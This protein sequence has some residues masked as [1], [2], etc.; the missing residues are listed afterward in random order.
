MVVASNLAV[1]RV[2]AELDDLLSPD[3]PAWDEAE[4]SAIALVPTP[5]ERQPSAYVQ[6]AWQDR[7]RGEVSEVRVRAVANTDAVTL[8]LEWGAER[9]Q[10]RIDDVNV[11]SDA[12]AVLFPEDGQEAD[13][14]TMG[15][16]EQPV[17]AW[18]WRAGSD[19]PF[20]ITAKG[21]GTVERTGEHPL[22][23]RSRWASGRWRVVLAQ[24]FAPPIQPAGTVP[25]AFAVWSGAVQERAGL[26][27]YSGRFHELRFDHE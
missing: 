22:R 3:A 24:P 1:H 2:D 12:C 27:S 5:L 21:L 18:F 11:F 20:S 25:I 6:A 19:E 8:R 9:P 7:A 23:C 13:L 17:L 16:P 15:S 26:K 10:R 14:D 4:E